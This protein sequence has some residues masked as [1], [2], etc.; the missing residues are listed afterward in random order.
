MVTRRICRLSFLVTLIALT[1]FLRAF[2]SLSVLFLEECY[3][4]DEVK[5][6]KLI[7]TE[8]ELMAPN[9][10]LTLAVSCELFGF[11]SHS[12]V[13]NL[14]NDVWTGAMKHNDLHPLQC[15][16]GIFFPPYILHFDFVTES[17]LKTMIC[18]KND[19]SDRKLQDATPFGSD[20]KDS[21]D[22]DSSDDDEDSAGDKTNGDPLEAALVTVDVEIEMLEF[23]PLRR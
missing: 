17:Q 4:T 14:L 10:S 3:R 7:T 21:S 18:S 9:T 2:E 22:E 16:A 20:D 19:D 13:H 12:C 11:V 23:T 1:F 15:I 8:L 5:T 6:E